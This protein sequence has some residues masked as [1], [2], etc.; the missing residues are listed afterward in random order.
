M[1]LLFENGI[2]EF[3]L[4]WT[5]YLNEPKLQLLRCNDKVFFTR[6]STFENLQLSR[7]KPNLF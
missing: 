5:S 2:D 4:A 1:T 3:C 6:H 7:F